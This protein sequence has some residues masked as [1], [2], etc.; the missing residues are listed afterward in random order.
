LFVAD[1]T[2]KWASR[3]FFIC[4]GLIWFLSESGVGLSAKVEQLQA[5]IAPAVAALGYEL[6]GVEFH[7]H[8]RPP[9]LRVFIDHENGI[10]VDD[11][12]SASRQISAV[13]D[14]E[15]PISTEYTLEVSSPGMDRPLFTLDQFARYIGEWVKVKLRAPF[16]GR[17]NFRGRLTGVEGDEIVVAV[18]DSEYLLP[19]ELVEKAN[20]IPQFVSEKS[21]KSDKGKT[22]REL[23]DGDAID[24]DQFAGE[25][26]EREEDDE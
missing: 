8:G 12:A 26:V 1:Q 22:K 2:N 9:L 6:W 19:I 18:D 3:P 20:V 17:R 5:M 13:L 21:G 25:P 14:V 16:E 7:G 24:D 11:C 4:A 15:D 23:S 10:N